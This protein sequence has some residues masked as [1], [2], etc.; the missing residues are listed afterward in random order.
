[1]GS[2]SLWPWECW[3]EA[4][5]CPRKR[6]LSC[7]RIPDPFSLEPIPGRTDQTCRS[8][9]IFCTCW[10]SQLCPGFP[11]FCRLL[12]TQPLP[13]QTDQTCRSSQIIGTCWPSQLCPGF[14][15]FC[16]LVRMQLGYG[17]GRRCSTCS[18]TCTEVDDVR[19]FHVQPNVHRGD[20]PEVEG[21]HRVKRSKPTA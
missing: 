4:A 2:P 21:A 5:W 3:T 16:R 10:S 13:G 12:R 6:F 9:Q 8:S 14:P 17:Q 15:G 20:T 11:G 1:M 19:V 7:I 18:S